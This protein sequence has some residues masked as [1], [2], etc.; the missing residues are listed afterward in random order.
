[1]WEAV[2]GRDLL[3][4]L[5]VLLTL[6]HCLFYEARLDVT[7]EP[8]W[9]VQHRQNLDGVAT[10]VTLPPIL[11]PVLADLDQ[12]GRNELVLIDD[13]QHLKVSLPFLTPPCLGL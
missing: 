10:A 2:R 12:D 6:Y 13:Q 11:P 8:L 9:F 7:L 3:V 4:L 1:M 5:L